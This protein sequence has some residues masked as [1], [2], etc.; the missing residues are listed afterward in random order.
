MPSDRC[1]ARRPAQLELCARRGLTSCALRREAG[2]P[3]LSLASAEDCDW[4]AVPGAQGRVTTSLGVAEQKLN[5][6]ADRFVRVSPAGGPH[7]VAMA[8]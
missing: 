1:L 5:A 7:A 6:H 4:R 2:C 8:R 3:C